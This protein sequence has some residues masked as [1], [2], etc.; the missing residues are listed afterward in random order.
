L[1]GLGLFLAVA[2]VSGNNLSACVGTA[3]G[4]RVIKPR[5]GMALGAAGFVVGMMGQGTAMTHTVNVLLPLSDVLIISKALFV[6]VFI[7]FLANVVRIP[8]PLTMSLVG[9]L[10]GVATAHHLPMQVD[11]LVTVIAV[12]LVAPALAL[13]LA[14]YSVRLLDRIRP[15]DFW[16]RIAVY[17]GVLVVFAFLNSYVLGANTIGL[18][19]AMSGFG[20]LTI[21]VGILGILVGSFFLSAGPI[22]RLGQDLFS[23]RYSNALVALI[24]STLLVEFATFFSI[25]LSNTQTLSASVLGEGLSYRHKLISAW[26]FTIIV[27]GWVI[28]PLL[29]FLFGLLL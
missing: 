21:A 14:F 25:P 4:G 24:M 29:S 12:W 5:T 6:I 19:V 22:R 2:F 11:F 1:L 10:V 7:F 3:I 17:K 15:V 18:L 20:Y 9:L 16:R 26:P 13:V 27:V 8:L 28:A 23:L